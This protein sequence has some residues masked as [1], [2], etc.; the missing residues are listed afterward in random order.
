MRWQSG[1]RELARFRESMAGAGCN[2]LAILGPFDCRIRGHRGIPALLFEDHTLISCVG[3]CTV[4]CAA[5][6]IFCSACN[7]IILHFCSKLLLAHLGIEDISRYLTNDDR[8][9]IPAS[10]KVR[11]RSILWSQSNMIDYY[12]WIN[13]PMSRNH[14]HDHYH[15]HDR[16]DHRHHIFHHHRHQNDSVHL[17]EQFSLNSLQLLREWSAHPK[18]TYP[19]INTPPQ[20]DQPFL[21]LS[22]HYWLYELTWTTTIKYYKIPVINK[23]MNLFWL[24]SISSISEPV[25]PFIVCINHEPCHCHDIPSPHANPRGAP[26]PCISLVGLTLPE[27]WF[28]LIM[29]HDGQCNANL[30]LIIHLMLVN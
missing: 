11:I 17:T 26:C 15:H 10:S 21:T 13:T 9:R 30:W 16:G 29:L 2:C 12:G 25:D 18:T 20:H 5:F 27:R 6:T 8:Q 1:Q 22:N 3:V 19:S 14:A 7:E 23:G 24:N 28:M 4:A